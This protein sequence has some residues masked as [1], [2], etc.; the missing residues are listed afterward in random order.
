[1]QAKIIG[2]LGNFS[3]FCCPP[4][5]FFKIYFFKKL[6]QECYQ[7]VKQ[8]G[9][10]SGPTLSVLIWDQTVS[11]GYQVACWVTFF[12]L[13]LSSADFS[14]FTSSKKFSN[15]IL[16]PDQDPHSVISDL[17]P[18]LFAKVIRRVNNLHAG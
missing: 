1:M 2:V 4:L 6:F 7:S 14:K 11:K 8:F 17:G 15:D 18:K 13:W 3:S 12:K 9:S 16:D 5:M 10:R